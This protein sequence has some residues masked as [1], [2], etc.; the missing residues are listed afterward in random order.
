MAH[1]DVKFGSKVGRI[2]PNGTNP[3]LFQIRFQ[4]IL[5]QWSKMYWNLIWES[6]EFVL[7]GVKLTHFSSQIRHLCT[8]GFLSATSFC[9]LII[10]SLAFSFL[11]CLDSL[12]WQFNKGIQ[13]VLWF[14]VEL[15]IGPSGK[16]QPRFL[17]FFRKMAIFLYFGN[18]ATFCN[19]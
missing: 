2:V 6:P 13:F 15:C 11:W 7:F 10:L 19:F 12:C 9:V 8:L 1:R 16:S 4:Y 17:V 14:L 5:T 18:L 3:V